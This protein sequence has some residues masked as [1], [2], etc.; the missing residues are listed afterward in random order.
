[1]NRVE[2]KREQLYRLFISDG[3]SE[4]EARIAVNGFSEELLK[5]DFDRCQICWCKKG[6]CDVHPKR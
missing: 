4:G 6:P 1:M 2:Q 5:T 3:Q